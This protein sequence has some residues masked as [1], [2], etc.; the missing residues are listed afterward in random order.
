MDTLIKPIASRI[1]AAFVGW[2]VVWL[3]AK[4]FNLDQQSQIDLIAGVTAVMVTAYGII[5]K[6]LDKK[7]NPS[8]AAAAPNVKHGED[9]K[10]TAEVLAANRSEA[11]N[12]TR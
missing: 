3:A 7:V 6:L 10:Y 8:D 2:L 11:P 1:A 4:G 9:V 5:H 12:G